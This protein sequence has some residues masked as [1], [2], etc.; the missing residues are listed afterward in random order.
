M[1]VSID[2]VRLLYGPLNDKVCQANNVLKIM[3]PMAFIILCNAIAFWK[4]MFILVWKSYRTIQDSF[5][6]FITVTST[7]MMTFL[8]S[9]AHVFGPGQNPK[10][11]SI[12]T[13]TLLPK[14]AQNGFINLG[15]VFMTGIVIYLALLVPVWMKRRQIN[16]KE[17]QRG[18]K[19]LAS[20]KGNI[21]LLALIASGG[22]AIS[23]MVS[24]SEHQIYF[25][26]YIQFMIPFMAVTAIA[27]RIL[28]KHGN[29]INKELFNGYFN[30]F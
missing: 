3:F 11:I 8:F 30:L 2:V 4:F 28:K 22:L 12:C 29:D 13:G 16:V 18:T 6:T 26:F 25:Y 19:N 14:S 7:L 1:S 21:I 23:K 24:Q 10:S 20:H 15:L 5:L 17:N 9:S 27:I